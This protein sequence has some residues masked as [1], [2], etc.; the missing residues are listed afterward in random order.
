MSLTQT[1]MLPSFQEILRL[2]NHIS[3]FVLFCAPSYKYLKIV[4]DVVIPNT[5]ALTKGYGTGLLKARY[6][7]SRILPHFLHCPNSFP[8]F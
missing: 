6:F 3:S 4:R 2:L 1:V 5:V 7:P 8:H